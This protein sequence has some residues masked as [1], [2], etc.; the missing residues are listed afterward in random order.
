M[1]PALAQAVAQV[2]DNPYLCWEMCR[3]HPTVYARLMLVSRRFKDWIDGKEEV[4]VYDPAARD[5][6]KKTVNK[7]ALKTNYMESW[8]VT[9]H[10]TLGGPVMGYETR[11]VHSKKEQS[12]QDRPS[13]VVFGYLKAWSKNGQ[14]YRKKGPHTIINQPSMF[15]YKPGYASTK[16]WPTRPAS[17]GPISLWVLQ[18]Q[19]RQETYFFVDDRIL[20][21]VHFNWRG[22]EEQWVAT[23]SELVDVR[24]GR[25][26]EICKTDLPK[27]AIQFDDEE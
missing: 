1:N 13:Q 25:A 11:F 12:V 14:L 18:G 24:T 5:F 27:A 23:H 21:N 6:R 8:V 2:F 4:L 7:D 15:A 9:V 26:T 16:E 10:R 20:K 22:P 17:E 3:W 19:W